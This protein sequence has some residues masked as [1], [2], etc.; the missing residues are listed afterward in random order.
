MENT[1][2]AS[3][4]SVVVG[5]IL[6][7][8][9]LVPVVDDAMVNA[10]STVKYENG[11]GLNP[12]GEGSDTYVFEFS[13]SNNTMTIN[14]VPHS[15]GIN[16]IN[17]ISADT[18]TVT[19]NNG[20]SSVQAFTADESYWAPNGLFHDFKI[21]LEGGHYTI[22]D[23]SK[24]FEGDYNWAYVYD[25]SGEYADVVTTAYVKSTDELII[26]GGYTSG[27]LDTYYSVNKGV[28]EIA[29]TD[30]SGTVSYT[31]ELVEGTTDIYK[32]S[33]TI[34]ISD[35]TITESFVPFVYGAYHIVE[36]HNDT[37]GYRAILGAIPIVVIIG[38]LV[39]SI[40]AVGVRN[41]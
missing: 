28:L 40:Y 14:G 33:P 35:G 13:R 9:L 26:S 10:G 17:W 6:L 3:I 22:V 36:G 32:V 37:G 5:I 12:I 16:R 23:G 30:Y 4:L 39:A 2:V 34:T 24:V 31:S 27:S 15:V 41:N 19:Q 1:H 38:F 7:A 29:N 25:P 20:G 11:N 18:L 8:T 21:T